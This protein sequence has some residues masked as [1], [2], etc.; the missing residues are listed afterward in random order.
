M[1]IRTKLGIFLIAL[2]VTM[3]MVSLFTTVLIS[4]KIICK[5]VGNHL[6]TTAQSRAHNIETL[7]ND[8]KKTVLVLSAGIPFTNVLDPTIDYDR[9]MMECDLR[10]QRTIT[11]NPDISMIRIL[12]TNGI[13]ICSNH[14]DVGIDQSADEIFLKGKENVYIGEIHKSEYTG[15]LV[16]SISA[17]IFVRDKFSGVVIINF[18][19]EEKLYEIITNRTGLGETGEIY[20]VNK[21]GYLLTPSRFIDV[22]FLKTKINTEQVNLCLLEYIEK[23][24]SS[25]MEEKATRYTN[26]IGR[27]VMGVCYFI[28]EM[29]WGLI[30][31]FDVK[32]AYKPMNEL[33]VLLIII[34][35]I[36]LIITI[37]VAIIISKDI[38]LPIEKLHKGAEEIIK[39][40][41]DYRVGIKTKD[42]IGQ[43]SRAFDLMTSRLVESQKELEKNTEKLEEKVKERTAQLD[44]KIAEIEQ[45]RM[46]TV[47]I[48]ND[49]EEINVTLQD[50]IDERKKAEAKLKISEK[51]YRALVENIQDGVFAIHDAKMLFV[52][53]AFAEM[54]GYS[55]EELIGMD[56]L[57]LIA[58]E[59][60]DM[61]ADRY[62]RRQAGEDVPGE[63]EFSMLHKDKTTR[64]IV[65]MNV[66]LV[67]YKKSVASMGTVKDITE[68][69][70]AEEALH[71]SETKYRLLAEN[72]LDCV[73]KMDKDLKFTY[74]NQS[75][76]PMLGFT[77]EEWVGSTLAE[78]CSEKELQRFKNIVKD[79]LRKEDTYSA[80][81]ELNLFHKNGSNVPLEV[82]G[83]IL[84]DENKQVIGFQG[85]ARDITERKQA[86]KIQRALYD[87]SNALNTTDNMSLLCQK[88]REFLGNVI[89]TKNF[90]IALYNEK[91]D[92]ISLPFE[93]DEKDKYESFPAGKTLT[94]YVIQLEKPL[95]APRKLQDELTEQG[96]IEVIGT[97]SEIWL[98]APLKVENSVIGVI[99]VQSYED[100]NLYTEKD[101]EILT[102][103]SEE[104][105]LAIKHKQAEEQMKRDLK[106][107][108]LL[109][110]EIHHRVKN[111]LQVISGLLQLQENEIT[112]KEDALK[113]FAASQD[114]I[115]AMAKAYE[116]LLGSEYM[117]EVKVGKYIESLAEQLK[118]N[119]DIQ[120]KVKISYSLE[121]L[122]ISI[123][124]LD[125][126]G[127][128]L[129]EIITNSIKYAFEGREIG[130]IHIE[131]KET[132]TNL[133]IK[134]S[135]DGIGIPED[136]DIN[137]PDTLGL[138][139][140][141]ML[142][143]QLQGTLKL[144]RKNGTSFTLKIP[145]ES[146]A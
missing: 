144:D 37:V 129:N 95:F 56:F 135:D 70:R 25:E 35:S 116:L 22:S 127:L 115:L 73:W 123:E 53:K 86:E 13:V 104:I 103:I 46:S 80:I 43:L 121:E 141:E 130:N 108:E 51:K 105:A 145:K 77:R 38:T 98:G 90:Y 125:R 110:R 100:P 3:L 41:L 79:E 66:G 96:K 91:T 26:F 140:V 78:H 1:K 17:P 72:T 118:R 136:I 62:H 133:V 50:E 33:A 57:N 32:E 49:L 107:K 102:F 39:G 28:S 59:D 60:I 122:E 12:N 15:N 68:R 94:K 146:E 18:D 88:V 117:S 143:V 124:I 65:N 27:K 48:A 20:L 137:N 83:K 16:L 131:L 138:S 11:V 55:E 74:I 71:K 42:E 139:L 10:I 132:E 21:D 45:Q 58:P 109:L 54:T 9:R 106:E 99:A 31:E 36:L 34:F 52:N 61:V 85:N 64:I 24:F 4:K 30:A 67:H 142:T 14:E 2:A 69:K 119:Y 92:V 44:K 47:N 120:K 101:I 5:Q 111:N 40:N 7:L 6:W 128:I 19:V 126:L 82:L 114:R 76:Y 112:T 87:I 84:F 8:Y 134:I 81:F 89:D 29:Q 63:Y 97:P 93:V 113:G 23:G 75:I